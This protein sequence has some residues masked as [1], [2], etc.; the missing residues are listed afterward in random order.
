M[1]LENGEFLSI[2]FR[3]VKKDNPTIVAQCI[4]ENDVGRTQNKWAR[5]ILKQRRIALRRLYF[6]CGA[7]ESF[8]IKIRRNSNKDRKSKSKNSINVNMKLREKLSIRIPNHAEEELI[9]EK[10]IIMQN[11]KMLLKRNLVHF[12]R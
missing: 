7:D 10:S 6:M 8:H 3:Q 11:G 1:E 9:S 2:T 12:K 4:V 5:N